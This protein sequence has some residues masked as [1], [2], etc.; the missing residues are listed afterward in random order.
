MVHRWPR[1]WEAVA[2][3]GR[4]AWAGAETPGAETPGARVAGEVLSCVL[5]RP[6]SH[7]EN[8]AH[9][10]STSCER[11]PAQCARL[12][13]KR[14]PLDQPPGTTRSASLHFAPRMRSRVIHGTL[15]VGQ[16]QGKGWEEKAKVNLLPGRCR[17]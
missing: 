16:S 5:G 9:W 1:R 8:S 14:V 15:A 13:M 4:T 2:A 7:L 10:H 17:W 12:Q 6:L 3:Q 11:Q